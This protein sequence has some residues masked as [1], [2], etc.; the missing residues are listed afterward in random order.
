MFTNRVHLDVKPAPRT[1]GFPLPSDATSSRQVSEMPT[2]Q[3]SGLLLFVGE[4]L[5]RSDAVVQN[6]PWSK[7]SKGQANAD[8][9]RN[10][11]FAALGRGPQKREQMTSG[12]IRPGHACSRCIIS[13]AAVRLTFARNR[14]SA[15]GVVR[16]STCVRTKEIVEGLQNSLCLLSRLAP[17]GVRPE[18]LASTGKWR[19]HFQSCRWSL[20]NESLLFARDP[21]CAQA[22]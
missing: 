1:S 16:W 8:S 13:A 2:I 11:R 14:E 5:G 22:D 19:R 15:E 18:P 20:P 21:H 10:A 4:C 7:P 17:P 6:A 12:R 3:E 9:V